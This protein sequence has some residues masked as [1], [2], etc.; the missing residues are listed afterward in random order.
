MG[1]RFNQEVLK[2]HDRLLRKWIKNPTESNKLK[3][4]RARNF[5]IKAIRIKIIVYSDKKQLG[6]VKIQKACSRLLLNFAKKTPETRIFLILTLL[7][8]FL[9]QLAEAEES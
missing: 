2:N 3:F 7:I 5:A 8:N 9:P 6:M 1:Y 4:C